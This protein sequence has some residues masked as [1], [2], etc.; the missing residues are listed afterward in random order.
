VTAIRKR[1][2][3]RSRTLAR[4]A[5]ASRRSPGSGGRQTP[6]DV[7][8]FIRLPEADQEAILRQANDKEFERY[9]THADL[10]ITAPMGQERAGKRAEAPASPPAPSFDAGPEDST[11]TCG[12]SSGAGTRTLFATCPTSPAKREVEGG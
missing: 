9:V 12:Y 10:K 5:T 3:R 7:Y 2:G 4:P 8:L 1:S 6:S 11:A